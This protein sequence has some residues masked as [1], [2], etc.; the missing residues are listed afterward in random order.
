MGVADTPVMVSP[1][2]VTASSHHGAILAVLPVALRVS[3]CGVTVVSHG[4]LISRVRPLYPPL[5]CRGVAVRLHHGLVLAVLPVA[6][7]VSG[8][9]VTVVSHG[10]QIPPVASRI[11]CGIGLWCDC[12]VARRLDILRPASVS[13]VISPRCDHTVAPRQDSSRRHSPW[14]A[15]P[16]R[17]SSTSSCLAWI[18]PLNP[19]L[20]SSR[21]TTSVR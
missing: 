12:C 9:G 3:G 21:M 20:M 14:S 6:L 5:S 4:G 1:R 13:A 17:I 11:R 8:C 15:F 10:W 2:G 19:G 16:S 18:C 7:R